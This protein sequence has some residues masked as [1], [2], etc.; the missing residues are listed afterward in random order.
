[1]GSR[2]SSIDMKERAKSRSPLAQGHQRG[3]RSPS[4]G[5][6]ASLNRHNASGSIDGDFLGELDGDENVSGMESDG[7]SSVHVCVACLSKTRLASWRG[8][9]CW[10]ALQSV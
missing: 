9:F 4:V 7:G 1:M 6:L 2:R 8:S 10:H 5:S 3:R